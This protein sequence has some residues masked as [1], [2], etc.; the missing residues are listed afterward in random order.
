MKISDRTT[1]G[2]GRLKKMA[3]DRKNRWRSGIATEPK[4]AGR[5]GCVGN[6]AIGRRAGGG[7]DG[8]NRRLCRQA[9]LQRGGDLA[10]GET[11]VLAVPFARRLRR[12]T[13]RVVRGTDDRFLDGSEGHRS[14]SEAA[15]QRLQSHQHADKSSQRAAAR[16]V[17][18]ELPEEEHGRMHDGEKAR[19]QCDNTAWADPMTRQEKARGP[20]DRGLL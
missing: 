13:I 17:T 14:A 10:S 4:V 2:R 8:R 5:K 20:E 9:G 7:S 11:A 1:A 18:D 3:S 16:R 15:D 19:C 6:V 12:T